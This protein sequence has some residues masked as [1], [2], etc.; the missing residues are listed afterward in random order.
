MFS[1][2]VLIYSRALSD[3]EIYNAYAYNIINASNLVLFLDPTFF[4]GSKYIDLSPY[5]N[6]G[7]PYNGVL[8]IPDN[9]TWIYLVKG[10]GSGPVNLRF[11]PSTTALLIYDSSGNVVGRID[12]SQLT[13]QYPAY[14]SGIVPGPIPINLPAGSYRLELY[15]TSYI[16]ITGMKSY[17]FDVTTATIKTVLVNSRS[18]TKYIRIDN[19]N[20]SPND[21]LAPHLYVWYFDGV[22]DYVAIPLTV[23]GWSGI[24]IQE[25][26][27][28]FYPKANPAWSK[29]SMIGDVWVDRPSVFFGTNDRYDYTGLSLGFFTRKQDGTNGYYGFSI[30]AYINRWVNTAWRFSLADRALI[31]YIN[32]GRVYTASVPST[33]YT[34]LEWNPATATYPL[35]YQQF[36]LGAN[37]LSSEN[38]KMMQGNI[39]IYSRALSDS[40]IYNAYAYNIINASN[41]VL[42][43]DPTFYNGTHFI[44]LSGYNNH[45]VGY[46]GVARIPDNRTWIYLVKNL[47]SDNLVHLRF[48]PVGTVYVFRSLAGYII[49]YGIVNGSVNSAGLVEDFVIN[50]PQGSY[51][52]E[53]YIPDPGST[54]YQYG[55]SYVLSSTNP[56]SPGISLS[57]SEPV[58]VAVGSYAYICFLP[59]YTYN[60]T[61]IRS[62]NMNISVGSSAYSISSSSPCINISSSTVSVVKISPTSFLDLSYN[63]TTI[64]SSYTTSASIVF[65]RIQIKFD[66]QPSYVVAV[67][68]SATLFGT[69]RYVSDG[70]PVSD[71]VVDISDGYNI[72]RARITNG[73]FSFSYRPNSTGTVSF[74]AVR[75]VDFPNPVSI[76]F[77]SYSENSVI[78]I[79]HAQALGSG[80]GFVTA[81]TTDMVQITF[82]VVQPV[83]AQIIGVS[84]FLTNLGSS[85]VYLLLGFSMSIGIFVI[86]AKIYDWPVA[87]VFASFVLLIMF[88]LA[89]LTGPATVVLIFLILF[90]AFAVYRS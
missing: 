3:S 81:Y 4:D 89:G 28:P 13:S 85:V 40:E 22:D 21:T 14:S 5:G 33:E 35:R 86:M 77:S 64:D 53:F 68:S 69:A 10:S 32:G 27:Y 82:Y 63:I 74:Y 16:Q 56:Y 47:S 54:T 12:F 88:L 39:L 38:M 9:R 44:D 26:L 72:Y 23:Y 55:S 7:V 1:A 24:T 19:I 52:V 79:A 8:R 58:R 29:F 41:L 90:L 80:Y 60:N 20:I 62:F 66:V 51:T 43:L 30:Y 87:G 6:N 84:T 73:Q 25:W 76:S 34:I 46:N 17:G 42:F 37:V 36:V 70:Y 48:F 61:L 57:S 49:S 67:N 50:I 71:G 11:F 31:I 18:P 59:F 75:A 45:G 2:Y 83:A 65:D 15:N 78:P